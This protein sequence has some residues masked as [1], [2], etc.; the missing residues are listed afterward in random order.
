MTFVLF[1]LYD[2]LVE[3]KPDPVRE[4]RQSMATDLGVSPRDLE[5]AERRTLSARMCGRFG[6]T[7]EDELAHIITEAGC[8][9][10]ASLVSQYRDTQ[11]NA[12][13]E[14]SIVHSDVMPC[15]RYLRAARIRLGL[16]SNCSRLT[17]PLLGGW[18]FG[19]CFDEVTL[20]C[21]IGCTKPDKEIL[22]TAVQA[23]GGNPK[24]GMLVDDRADFVAAA[25]GFGLR[26]CQIVR[27]E[28]APQ[29]GG[30]MMS[31]RACVG[32]PTSSVVIDDLRHLPRHLGGR[33]AW[34]A[35]RARDGSFV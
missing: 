30:P 35:G 4:A 13:R 6:N 28:S 3:F 10:H 26:G 27:R 8:T 19:G 23:V 11:L 7:L 2:T 33:Q 31:D 15:L 20:S 9:P 14:A 24:D 34:L 32:A 29:N 17:R 25:T 1:D 12:W 21:E 16:V 22:R 18:P 5:E